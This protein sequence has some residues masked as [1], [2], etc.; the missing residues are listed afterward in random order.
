[1][2]FD[3]IPR[4]LSVKDTLVELTSVARVRPRTSKGITDLFLPNVSMDLSSIIS[5]RSSRI[6]GRLG[7]ARC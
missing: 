6:P 7:G 2:S 3:K 5:L 1:M 4:D